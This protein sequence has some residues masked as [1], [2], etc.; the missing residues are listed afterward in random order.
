MLIF[1]GLDGGG[2]SCRAQAELQDGRRTRVAAGGAAN[3]FSNFEG[4]LR[5]ISGVLA[6]V[7]TQAHALIPSAAQ[8][9]THIVMGLA[10]AS[11]SGAAARL[12]SALPYPNLSVYGDIDISLSGAFAERDGIVLAV[13][14]GSVLASQRSGHMQRLGGYGFTLGDEGSGAWIGRETLRYCLHARDGFGLDGPLIDS[15]RDK[16]PQLP[17]I[18]GFAG[19]ASAAD[20]AALAPLVLE[21]DRAY[22]P[23]AGA[24]LDQGC[25]YLLRAITHL[26]GGAPDI[27]VAPLGG[28]GPA[29]LD[30]IMAKGGAHLRPVAPQGTALDGAIWKARHTIETQELRP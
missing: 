23:V 29:L 1:I 26:Q 4:A 12:T 5:E 6:N 7:M 15:I 20:F 14:T 8:T 27:P 11:E 30:R 25:A 19:R 22:C 9:Q 3:I 2:T 17:D 18:I 28:L 13:G 24:I 16:F 21:H 10:G